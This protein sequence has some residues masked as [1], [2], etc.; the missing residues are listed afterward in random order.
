MTRLDSVPMRPWLSRV[1]RM[2]MV[3]D[4]EKTAPSHND[5]CQDQP[6]QPPTSQ[7]NPM[8]RTI[9]MGV[10]M[11]ATLRT[12][13]R[14]RR[15]NSSPMPNSSSATPIS[16]SISTSCME[17]MTVPP[18]RGPSAMPARMYPMMSGWRSRWA[19]TPKRS[20]KTK[21]RM[22]SAAMPICVV[23]QSPPGGPNTTSAARQMNYR[24]KFQRLTWQVHPASSTFF[25]TFSVARHDRSPPRASPQSSRI[26]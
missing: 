9:W 24:I 14:S 22:M 13:L 10:P 18:A 6:S 4:S 26:A 25:P 15:E 2:T 3:L 11:R 5:A 12:G 17:W 1:L 20:P 23:L 7:P 8:T 16:A 21:R 19:T